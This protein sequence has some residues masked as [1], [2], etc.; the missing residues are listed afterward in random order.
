MFPLVLFFSRKI[1][2]EDRTILHCHSERAHVHA[3]EMFGVTLELII[4]T[5][6]ESGL[7]RV[8]AS[9]VEY[10]RNEGKLDHFYGIR[11]PIGSTFSNIKNTTKQNVF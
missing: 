2:H 6:G 11:D 10:L 1:K 4:G 7:P 8:V 3:Q 5:I 9:C